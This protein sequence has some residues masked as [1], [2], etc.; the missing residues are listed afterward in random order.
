MNT[1]SVV[2]EQRQSPGCLLQLLWFALVGWWLGELWI[3]A[4]WISMVTIIGLPLGIWMLNNLPKVIAL[5]EPERKLR[6]TTRLDGTSRT[7]EVQP[8]QVPWLLR[9]LYFVLIGWWLTALW[10]EAAY[11]ISLT[12]IGLP[13]GFWMFDRVPALLSLRRS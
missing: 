6:I 3:V 7:Q 13:V 8:D 10:M 11:A 4:A 1:N 5:R 12:I 9:A 2:I